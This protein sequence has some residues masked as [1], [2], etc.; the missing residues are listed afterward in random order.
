M[1]N[2]VMIV[3]ESGTGKSTS[4]RNLNPKETYIINCA[5]KPLPFKGSSAAYSLEN[6][7]KYESATSGTILGVL[8][9]IEKAPHI[10]NVIIDD[11]N[12]V[13]TDMY[14]DKVQ[15]T[16]YGKFTQIAKAFQSILAKA[17]VMRND[18]NIAIMMHEENEVSNSV[19]IAKK[20]KTVGKMVDDQYSPQSVVSIALYTSVSFDKESR[21][22]YNFVTN[23]TLING[24]T[25]PAKS[26]QEMFEDL[27]IP[28]DLAVVFQKAKEYY[29]N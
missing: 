17:K 18:L 11:A 19:V 10:K 29:G 7:N 5:G 2:V 27:Y 8:D 24:I 25:I 14:F 9:Q 20:I 16:G 15:E 1:A 23:R 6:K 12:F 28:N 3:G 13:M 22:T 21:P 4:L 26:P